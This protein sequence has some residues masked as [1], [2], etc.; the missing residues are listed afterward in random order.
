MTTER[1]R[2]YYE[3]LGVARDASVAEI[4]KAYRQLAVRFHPDRN[5]DQ[6]EAEDRFKEASEAYAILS[7]P[8]KRSRY[9]RFGHDGVSENGFTGFDPSAFGDFADILG[10]LFGFGFGDIFGGRSRSGRA[11]P[12]R[13]RD[14]QYTLGLTLEEAAA[15]AERS[16]RIPRQHECDACGGS[17]SEPGTTPEPC[18]TCHGAGQVMFRRGFLSVSQTCPSCGGGGRVNRN[19]CH[20]C[21]G[22]GRVEKEANLQVSVP[23]GVETGMRLRLSGEGEAG[24][25]GGP[26][27]DLFILIAVE[28]HELFRRNGADLH[29]EVPVSVYQAMLG[30]TVTVPTILGEERS[31]EVRAGTQPG[32]VIRLKGDG[33]PRV[34]A[35]RRGDLFVHLRVVI[36]QRL[37]SEQRKLVTEA[38]G[39]GDGME[40]ADQGGFFDRIK[41]AF[42]TE[43]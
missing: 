27:G 40:G 20:Q 5:P 37:T 15:G 41:R 18:G 2:D 34:D 8:D 31:P 1:K 3:V 33:M 36:P 28:D 6:P 38:A 29:I 42:G 32:D 19:P 35:S 10:D 4:K 17:G 14:L 26:P 21:S 39:F 23:A 30:G 9:D 12:R 7:D 25:R 13:G 24:D 11:G 16:V 43:E 22:R